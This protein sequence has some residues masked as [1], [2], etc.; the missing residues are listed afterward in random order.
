MPPELDEIRI[1]YP[2]YKDVSDNDLARA[3]SA[4]YPKYRDLPKKLAMENSVKPASMPNETIS[5]RTYALSEVPGAML[6]N[7][8]SSVK[9][10]VKPFFEA[11]TYKNIGELMA[12]LTSADY[13]ERMSSLSNFGSGVLDMLSKRYGGWDEVKRTMAEDPAGVVQDLATF[14]TAGGAAASKVGPVA[15]IGQKMMGIGA[16]MDPIS[17]ASTAVGKTIAPIAR[18]TATNLL[19]VSTGKG[20]LPITDAMSGDP[21]FKKA[22]RGEIVA[23]EIVSQTR[24][25]LESIANQRGIDYRTQLA[26]IRANR[27]VTLDL[28]AP[29][30]EFQSILKT[31]NVDPIMDP[32]GSKMVGLDFKNS[33]LLKDSESQRNLK[34][35]MDVLNNSADNP[36][37]FASPEGYDILKKQ[38]FGI[39]FD[40][41]NRSIRGVAEAGPGLAAVEN[42]A[43][44]VRN[45]LTSKVPGYK[46]MVKKYEET[47][48]LIRQAQKA[49]IT[50]D[51]ND[52]NGTISKLNNAMREDDD[53]RRL[54]I[55]EVEEKTGTN[56]SAL[57]SGRMMS[58]WTPSG[59]IGKEL[60]VGAVIGGVIFQNPAFI[61]MV[62]TASPRIV[63]ETLHL[64]ARGK[65]AIEKTGVTQP[66]LRQVG[67]QLQREEK[68][69]KDTT[70]Y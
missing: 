64:L 16:A 13:A 62:A 30:R 20:K 21:L 58:P 50:R 51:K 11:E 55:K 49:T 9:G 45:E 46:E 57:V 42:V 22:L 70:L 61:P 35:I 66:W 26:H 68:N 1:K 28:S 34:D 27:G 4:M 52:I 54:I 43:H 48:D 2:E 25:A 18:G 19:G 47:T 14:F 39:V 3:L 12:R 23:E 15:N 8:G 56:I 24:G 37:F 17:M 63:A 6:S 10:V 31:H 67:Y 69:K 38:L 29:N 53:F 32:S 59:L 44:S 65:Q 41:R 40:A 36:A 33:P 7:L 60:G 5:N